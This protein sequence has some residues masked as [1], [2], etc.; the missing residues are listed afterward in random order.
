MNLSIY[1][2]RVF[3]DTSYAIALASSND[4]HHMIARLL[5]DRLEELSISLVTTRGVLLE[6]GNA[7]ARHRFRGEAITLLSNF[8]RDPSVEIV[9]LSESLY[10]RAFHLFRNRT[11]KEWGLVDCVSFVV[12]EDQ[13]IT[14][15]L[16]S[17]NHF[18]QAG[19]RP[20]MLDSLP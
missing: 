9:P 19:F 15:V 6:I 10:S 12:M 3:L 14:D 16:T 1:G 4:E 20:L 7:L 5:S 2:P 11:D 17:D 13:G 18:R 8:D